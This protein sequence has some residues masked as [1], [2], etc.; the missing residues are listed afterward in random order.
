MR[1]QVTAVFFVAA[2]FPSI[3]FGA[4]SVALLTDFYF[5]DDAAL[6]YSL[7]IVG[8]VAMTIA[9]ICL[10]FGIRSYRESLQRSMQWRDE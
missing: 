5:H 10:A 8:F 7:A 2:S 3:A 1:A 4:T 9:A 6:R